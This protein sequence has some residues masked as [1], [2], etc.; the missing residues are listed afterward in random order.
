MLPKSRF[1]PLAALLLL[2]AIASCKEPVDGCD[3]VPT[4]FI[5]QSG[6]FDF[7]AKLA[8]G[9]LYRTRVA[10]RLDM[11]KVEGNTLP[12]RLMIVSP[13]GNKVIEQVD[14]PLSK[15]NSAVRSRHNGGTV[16]DY[17]WF[18]REHIDV[19]DEPGKWKISIMPCDESILDG[20]LGV[21]FAY[22]LEDGKR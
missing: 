6:S 15:T 20:L 3:F 14:F 13:A 16:E 9:C 1:L 22:E 4:S 8:S 21:G 19:S 7:E 18:Y 12:L 11:G 2:F 5:S 17:E 10:V